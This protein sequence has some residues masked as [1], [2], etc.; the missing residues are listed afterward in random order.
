MLLTHRVTRD[1]S[2]MNA[3]ER[4]ERLRSL[5]GTMQEVLN[6]AGQPMQVRELIGAV[7]R[8]EHASLAD[9]QYALTFAR[10]HKLVTV[11]VRKNT[12]TAL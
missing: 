10:S 4:D 1:T 5:A 8:A 2:S 6:E 3:A 9:V 12:A 11:D 7:V